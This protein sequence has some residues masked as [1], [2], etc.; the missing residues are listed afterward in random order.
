MTKKKQA[1]PKK[2]R[3]SVKKAAPRAKRQSDN[4]Q[5][6]LANREALW[7]TYQELQSRANTAWTKLREDVNKHAN[8]ETIMQDNNNLLLLLGGRNYITQECVRLSNEHSKKKN[9]R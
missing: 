8:A 2:A 9:K 1:T 5:A 6:L 7:K 3:K 4:K